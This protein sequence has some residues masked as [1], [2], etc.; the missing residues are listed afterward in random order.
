MY[1]SAHY[2]DAAHQ[3]IQLEREEGDICF[4]PVQEGNTDYRRLVES[5]ITIAD[6]TPPQMPYMLQ[7]QRAYP[8]IGDQLDAIWKFLNQHRLA[9]HDL[10]SDADTMLGQ[11][12]AVKKQYPKP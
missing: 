3:I 2:Y 12:L 9:G 7:R 8:A 11:V 6:Y 5:G 1:Y 10:P 4:I